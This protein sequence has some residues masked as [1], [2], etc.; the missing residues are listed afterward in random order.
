MMTIPTEPPT[1]I[2]ESGVT[3]TASLVPERGPSAHGLPFR[4]RHPVGAALLWV[5]ALGLC[6]V[7]ALEGVQLADQ[8]TAVTRTADVAYRAASVVDLVADGNVRVTAGPTGTIDVHRQSHAGFFARP[9]Y[10][11][12]LDADT[13]TVRHTCAGST[14]LSAVCTADLRVTTPPGTRVVVRTS[15]GTIQVVDV[16]GDLDLRT[17]YGD[18]NVD[19]AVGTVTAVTDSGSVTVTGAPQQVSATSSYGNVTVTGSRGTVTATSSTGTVRVEDTAGPVTARTSYGHVTVTNAT[20]AVASAETG[21][22]VVRGVT[23]NIE[24][25]TSYGDATV[26]STGTGP[27]ALDIHTDYGTTTIQAPTDPAAPRSITVVSSTG[28]VAYLAG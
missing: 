11:A 16:T 14:L 19:G 1:V 9:T 10:S 26:Y 13:L 18:V 24:A 25:R 2:N 20:G 21:S 23:G 3:P 6:G 7:I 28:N 27:V 15:A 8:L 17:G 22:V 12:A 5:G 4:R